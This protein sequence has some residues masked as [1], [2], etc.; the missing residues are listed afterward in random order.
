MRAQDAIAWPEVEFEKVGWVRF[1][2]ISSESAGPAASTTTTSRPPDRTDGQ[3]VNNGPVGP[4]SS[5]S[6]PTSP[7]ANASGTIIRAVAGLMLLLAIAL[8]AVPIAK[9]ARRSR[10]R[11]A[12]SSRNQVLFAWREA[13]DRLTEAGFRPRAGRPKTE[14]AARA[15]AHLRTPA[16]GPLTRL[17]EVV[18]EV[19][20]GPNQ[21]S[22]LDAQAAWASA[23]EWRQLLAQSTSFQRRLLRAVDP[24]PLFSAGR[25]Y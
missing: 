2:P 8:I 10:R 25:R 4:N 24:R 16:D 22:A 13:L 23:D 11:A 1:D 19:L 3:D 18:N 15:A 20:Y 12:P 21:P 5:V 6:I 7:G 17:S 14:T 9:S